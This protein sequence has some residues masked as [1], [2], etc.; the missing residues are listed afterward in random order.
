MLIFIV[1]MLLYFLGNMQISSPTS[2]EA[3][4]KSINQSKGPVE[5]LIAKFPGK[6]F[7]LN[8]LYILYILNILFFFHFFSAGPISST[9]QSWARNVIRHRD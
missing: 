6:H 3:I 5:T 2:D 9:L 8:I 4:N 1:H 7:I